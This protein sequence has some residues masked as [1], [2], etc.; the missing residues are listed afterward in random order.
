M[1]DTARAK[2]KSKAESHGQEKAATVALPLCELLSGCLRHQA[3][4]IRPNQHKTYHI[5]VA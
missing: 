3:Y 4:S 1:K 5:E 2:E